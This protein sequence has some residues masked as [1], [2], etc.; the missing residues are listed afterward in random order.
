MKEFVLCYAKSL[1]HPDADWVVLVDR[2]K[3]K[4]YVGRLDL[5]G[6]KVRYGESVLEAASRILEAK[7]GI[8]ANPLS[9]CVPSGV[10]HSDS[11][12][13]TVVACHFTGS[14]KVDYYKEETP[15]MMSLSQAICHE[16]RIVSNLRTI[17]PLC[18][19]EQP[20]QMM[21]DNHPYQSRYVLYVRE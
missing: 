21:V 20:W 1:D 5:P 14:F 16:S 4:K 2:V 7:T 11:W 10:I 15:V 19:S 17:I 3:S 12:N 9:N 8:F 18:I 13:V 6:G